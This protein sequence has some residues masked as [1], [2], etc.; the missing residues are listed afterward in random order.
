[1]SVLSGGEK[2]RVALAKILMQPSNLLLMDEPTNHLDIASREILADAL[3]AYHGTIC[4][5]THDRTLIQ[6]TANKIIE[7]QAGVPE[8]FPGDYASYLYRKEHGAPPPVVEKEPEI[9]ASA[10]VEE[11]EFDDGRGWIA[12]RQPPKRKPKPPA[13]P[14]I[15]LL[16][17]LQQASKEIAKQLA[18]NEAQLATNE[19]QLA[20]I[21]AAFAEPEFYANTSEVQATME[22]HHQL[23]LDIQRL[24][25][26]WESLSL[27]AERLKGELAEV[28]GKK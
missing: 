1:V 12:V 22:K 2:A 6:Q 25:A 11:D 8:I 17:R 7:I 26:E 15:A 10:P 4:L 28:E 27:E 13:D 18:D 9:E 20:G 23:K 21:E 16:K 14:K 3:E 19:A 5:I 24:T